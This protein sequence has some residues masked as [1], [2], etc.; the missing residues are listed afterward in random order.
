M[1]TS[2]VTTSRKEDSEQTRVDGFEILFLEGLFCLN[3]QTDQSKAWKMSISKP[4]VDNQSPH[5]ARFT[6]FLIRCQS[7]ELLKVYGFH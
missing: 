7:E 2:L 5:A 1:I 6:L 3:L 4:L